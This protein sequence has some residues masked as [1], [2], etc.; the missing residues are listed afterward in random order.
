[1]AQDLP[2]SAGHPFYEALNRLLAEADFDRRVA[3]RCARYY[4]QEQ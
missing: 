3:T 4:E 1:M 2:R